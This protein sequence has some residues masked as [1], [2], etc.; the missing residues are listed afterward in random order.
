MLKLGKL[1]PL[2]LFFFKIVLAILVT[3]PFHINL[4]FTK[5]KKNLAEIPIGVMFNLC[6]SLGRI[7]IF[8]VFWSMGLVWFYIYLDILLF[9]LSVFCCFQCKS[10]VHILLDLYTSIS[11]WR[12]IINGT[13]LNFFICLWSLKV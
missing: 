7:D 4:I 13:I 8:F 2:I 1:I 6:I 11:L 12:A 10:P 3:L 5:K 9:L